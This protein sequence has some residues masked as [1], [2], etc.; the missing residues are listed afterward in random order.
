MSRFISPLIVVAPNTCVWK[1]NLSCASPVAVE[2]PVMHTLKGCQAAIDAGVIQQLGG[3][4]GNMMML[5]GNGTDVWGSTE[6]LL[7]VHRN[8]FMTFV[9]WLC[10]VTPHPAPEFI[11]TGKL[12][13]VP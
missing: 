8:T 10:S 6:S 2:L 3:R 7:I 4:F 12:M 9:A 5:A 1:C 11:S 13:K